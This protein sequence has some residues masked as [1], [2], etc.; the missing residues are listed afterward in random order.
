MLLYCCCTVESK[1]NTGPF[2]SFTLITCWVSATYREHLMDIRN[3]SKASKWIWCFIFTCNDV[4][5]SLGSSWLLLGG[6][7]MLVN[8]WHGYR[9]CFCLL[10]SFSEKTIRKR[11]GSSWQLWLLTTLT[12]RS[13]RILPMF[14]IV[15]FHFPL[16]ESVAEKVNS[17]RWK[18]WRL[19]FNFS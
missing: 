16:R 17:P 4:D 14:W 7:T 8:V 10:V 5:L 18:T 3:A 15:F 1:L 9:L 6:F 13:C 12:D 11:E 19:L 2:S